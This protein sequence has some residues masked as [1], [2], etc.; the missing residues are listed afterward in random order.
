MIFTRYFFSRFFRHFFLINIFLTLLFTLI[1]FFEKLLRASHAGLYAIGYFLLLNILPTFFEYFPLS[2]WLAT[3]M[4]IKEMLLQGEW[5]SLSL[6]GVTKRTQLRLFFITGIILTLSSFVGKEYGAHQL[7]KQTEHIRRTVFKQQQS[8]TLY[9]RWF[10]LGSNKFCSMGTINMESGIGAQLTLL[11]LN[12]AFALEKM[13][14]APTFSLLGKNNQIRFPQAK[15]YSAYSDTQRTLIDATITL[16]GIT[17]QLT[18]ASQHTPTLAHLVRHM[19]FASC[20]TTT[21]RR[22]LLN[23]FLKRFLWHFQSLL[24]PLLTFL[25]FS[26]LYASPRFMWLSLFAVYPIATVVLSCVDMLVSK[27]FSPLFHL[28]PYFIGLLFIAFLALKKQ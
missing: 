28:I 1:E 10:D 22:T 25:L 24:Y 21:V 4:L 16:P 8:S 18:L 13:I 3:C 15:E 5:E 2:S 19:I 14:T 11:K 20:A 7:T 6:L 27:G 23:Q 9:N 12:D 26:L 17:S